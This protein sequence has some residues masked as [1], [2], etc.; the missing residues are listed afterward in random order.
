[1]SLKKLLKPEGSLT[2]GV[3]TMAI[4]YAI[5]SHS[6]PSQ[7]EIHA[8]AANDDNIEAA[9]KKAIISSAAVVGGISLIARDPT[10]FILG[11][12]TAVGLDFMARHA[13]ATSPETGKLVAYGTTDTSF[14]SSSVSQLSAVS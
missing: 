3:A 10:V 2:A 14:A 5:Y 11:S 13:N 1:V 7:A 4:V 12:F 6:L 9:R 8:T